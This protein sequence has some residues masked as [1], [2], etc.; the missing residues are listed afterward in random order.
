M[1]ADFRP[2]QINK[3]T[4]KFLRGTITAP[5]MD[6]LEKWYSE[7]SLENPEW[8]L[9]NESR[10]DLKQRLFQNIR[11]RIIPVKRLYPLWAKIAAAVLLITTAGIAV[12]KAKQD[13]SAGQFSVMG[14]PGQIRKIMLPDHS[15][16]WLKGNS[17][18]SYPAHFSDST[19]NVMLHGEALFEIS[20]DRQ[21]PFIISAG[22]YIT[23]V[24]GTSFNIRSN[25][26]GAFKLTVLTGKV[27]VFYEKN[28]PNQKPVIV[29]PG[30]VYEKLNPAIKPSLAVSTLD[31]KDAV[32]YGTQYPM[33]FEDTRFEEIK[34]RIEEKFDVSITTDQAAYQQCRISANVTDQSLQN[35][36]KVICAS[37]GAEFSINNDQI[38]I[39][40]G[41]C[42]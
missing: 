11:A 23:R 35:T 18:I 42:N 25:N 17:S 24:L 3:L 27:Q 28:L 7:K 10:E 1:M 29:T 21:H 5:E 2:E 33:A 8:L 14:R 31:N 20:K 22:K 12:F 32:V 41:G 19:R 15:L 40:G 38:K 26:N 6:I 9:E 39:T 4:Q 16:V 13:T 34:R 30:Q 37:I 36:L